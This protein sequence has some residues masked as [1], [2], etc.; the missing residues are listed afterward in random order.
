MSALRLTSCSTA[1]TFVPGR[2]G[3]WEVFSHF[4]DR[5]TKGLINDI[6]VFDQRSENLVVIIL[7]AHFT[8]VPAKPLAIILA[9][10][11]PGEN[12][13]YYHDPQSKHNNTDMSKRRMK[14]TP[15]L[16]PQTLLALE[17]GQMKTVLPLSG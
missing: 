5:S 6:F 8:R 2:P 13:E 4:K 1:P 12:P 14:Q 7:G 15:S 17:G 9:R 3:P 10:M 11:S 16:Q